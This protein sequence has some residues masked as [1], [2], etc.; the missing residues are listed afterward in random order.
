MTD[1]IDEAAVQ[2]FLRRHSPFDHMAQGDLDFLSAR[3]RPIEF[4]AGDAITD[5]DAGPAEWFYVLKEGR[6]VGDEQ[7]EDERSSGNAWELVPG[8]CFPI[9]ALL[10]RRPVRNAQRAETDVTCLTMDRSAFDELRGRSAVFSEFCTSRLSSLLEQVHQQVQAQAIRDLGGDTSLNVPLGQKSLREP[11]TCPPDTPIRDALRTM[12]AEKVGSMVVADSERR[13]LG[14]FTLK[15]LMNRVALKN[16]PLHA[17]IGE[18]M[19]RDPVTVSRGAFAFEAAMLMAH[20]GIQ[21]LCVVE[22]QRLVGV[23]SERDL[24]SM[25]RVGLVNLSK[26]IGRAASVP[27]LA[28]IAKDIHQLVAQMIAQGVKVG[29]ITQIITLLNDQILERILELA[30]AD[31]QLP[32]GLSFTWLAFG[33]EG[34]HEQTLKTDQDNGILFAA[35]DG[36]S[37]ENARRALLP[38]AD[39]VNRDLD[40]CGF[41]LCPGNIMARNPEC[42]LSL[43]EWE[44][45]FVRW[46]DQGTPEH[47]LKSSIFFDFRPLHGPSGPARE[48][49]ERLLDRTARNSRFLKQMAANALR[50]APP[51]GLIRD[52]RLSGS[53]DQSNTIDLKLNGVTPFIDAARIFALANRIRATN[54]QERLSGAAEAGV[55]DPGDASAWSD[56]Y[57][58]IRMLRMRINQEQALAGLPLSNRIAPDRL[59]DLDRRILKEAFREARRMQSKLALDYQL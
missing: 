56:A 8:E 24:F 36:M 41:T 4:A 26:S 35:P 16:V 55:L 43:E 25:Q 6:I 1:V 19:S 22:D 40:A 10:D 39:R 5:P 33:S 18:V 32:A 9:G 51:L 20:N 17:P 50:N 30:L 38:L 44:A 31:A 49:R 29:Q 53:G 58:Y 23:I 52:F 45:R 48:L 42:C 37:A 34:R 59:N 57:D 2:D 7:G 3:L 14:I 12:G 46:I 54:T 15:D 11:L 21:H 28:R 27:E 47:L 13:P